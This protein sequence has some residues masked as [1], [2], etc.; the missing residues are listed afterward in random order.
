MLE[1]WDRKE[2]AHL[3]QAIK[4]TRDVLQDLFDE[5]RFIAWWGLSAVL[6]GFRLVAFIVRQSLKRR[7]V[8]PK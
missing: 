8:L 3:D 7:G 2:L 1:D 6:M 4:T 5:R